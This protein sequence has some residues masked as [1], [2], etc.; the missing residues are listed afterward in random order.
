MSLDEDDISQLPFRYY[1]VASYHGVCFAAGWLWKRVSKA[2]PSPNALIKRKSCR[3][4]YAYNTVGQQKTSKKK[5][6]GKKVLRAE[7]SRS[8]ITQ[9][10]ALSH[11]GT[12]LLCTLPF[13]FNS[14]FL[15]TITR[16]NWSCVQ[17][18]TSVDGAYT[19]DNGQTLTIPADNLESGLVSLF[20]NK[21]TIQSR[22]T[23]M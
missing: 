9:T 8:I 17:N 15:V 2:L 22:I 6:R 10:I 20:V 23:S 12:I 16:Y 1:A 5:E 21:P 13:G 19:S 18:C 4:Q 11:S 14:R 3:E 7:C